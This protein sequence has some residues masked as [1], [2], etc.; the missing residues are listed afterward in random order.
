VT[1]YEV[2]G[3]A[4]SAGRDELRQAYLSQARRH[5]PD[6]QP[7]K[8]KRVAAEVRMREINQAWAVLG[9]PDR[10]RTYDAERHAEDRAVRPNNAPHP[11]FIPIDDEDIDYAELL[12]DT[13][14]DGTDVPRWLQVLPAGLLALGALAIIA[15]FIAMLGPL[16]AFG[17]FLLVLA[18]L[19]FLATPAV[20]VMRSYQHDRR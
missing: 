9:H 16:V 19:S 10:R 6:R 5:H 14:M 13:P 8:A 7:D 3:V 2:L 17:A 11:D 4:E 18:V 12:D 1:H 15:G 20:A